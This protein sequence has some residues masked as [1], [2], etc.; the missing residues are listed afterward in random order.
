[1][2]NSSVKRATDSS[3]DNIKVFDDGSGNLVQAAALLDE[4]ADL[5]GT[6]SNP[7]PI[8][9]TALD[10]IKVSVN[11][12]GI[13]D[14]DT[15]SATVTYV[16][17]SDASGVWLVQKIDTSSGVAIGWASVTN[18]AGYLTYAAAWT[19]RASLT[20]GRYDEAF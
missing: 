13:N 17:K 12:F 14:V 3:G 15:A 10:L 18:N 9:S 7:L 1:M 6:T 19:A 5:V 4:N 2:I 11:Q 16:G 20:Y 8:T